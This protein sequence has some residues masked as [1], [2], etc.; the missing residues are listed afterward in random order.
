MGTIILTSSSFSEPRVMAKFLLTVGD[1]KGKN[2][3][4]VTTACEEK[5]ND[6]YAKLTKQQLKEKGFSNINFVDLEFDSEH[7]FSNCEVI[8]VCG[9]NTFKLMKFAR[10]ANFDSTIRNL[11]KRGGC[12]MGVSAGSIIVG[13]SIN[14]AS[15]LCDDSNKIGLT[16][17]DGFKL[18][19]FD[20]LPHYTPSI[21][22]ATRNFEEKYS[23]KVERLTDGSALIIKG[24][25]VERI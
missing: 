9:G 25:Q 10:N 4:I 14:I 21:E 1:T 5:E 13:S 24:D 17:M 16:D 11:I 3:S 20:I 15:E 7:D 2:V 8:H 19:P 22:T 18:V 6:T 23:T 12:Y